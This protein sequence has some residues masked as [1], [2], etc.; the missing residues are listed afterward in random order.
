[1]GRVPAGRCTGLQLPAFSVLPPDELICFR[2]I[3]GL[4]V[5][6]IPVELLASAI[7][8]RSQQYRLGQWTG[9]VE[10]GGCGAA[11]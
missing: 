5:R 1:M 2:A 7:G 11:A 10:T 4:Q 9:I 3:G 8:D 6:R